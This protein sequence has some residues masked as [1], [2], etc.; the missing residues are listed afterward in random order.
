MRTHAP[1]GLPREVPHRPGHVATPAAFSTHSSRWGRHPEAGTWW[2]SEHEPEPFGGIV[3]VCR[4]NQAAAFD[5]ISRSSR[6]C[7]FSRR[8]RLSSSRSAVVS[9]SLRWPALRS[10]CATQLRIDCAVGSNSCANS[11]G[12]HQLDMGWSRIGHR[13][14]LERKCSRVHE[15]GSTS[16]RGRPS[17]SAHFVTCCTPQSVVGF[18]LQDPSGTGQRALKAGHLPRIYS[19]THTSGVMRQSGKPQKVVEPYRL[20]V[21]LRPCSFEPPSVHLAEPRLSRAHR[22]Y[23][24]QVPFLPRRTRTSTY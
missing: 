2:Q 11:S 15:T 6:S 5:R 19:A 20:R 4:A 21:S 14:L 1:R 13:G 17:R 12:V 7:R 18:G 9:P 22:P 3:F 23:V 16:R 24:L 8:S 10:A